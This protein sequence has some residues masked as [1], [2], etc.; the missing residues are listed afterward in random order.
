M[1]E[2]ERETQGGNTTNKS[3]LMIYRRSCAKNKKMGGIVSKQKKKGLLTQ[4]NHLLKDSKPVKF[5]KQESVSPSSSESS[6]GHLG[7]LHSTL[8]SPV[9]SDRFGEYL[10]NLDRADMLDEDDCGRAE[11]LEFVLAVQHLESCGKEEIP[12]LVTEIGETFFRPQGLD[13][14]NRE[15]WKKCK[16]FC[17][18]PKEN[19]L[20][21][22]VSFL[23]QAHNKVLD[24]L[25]PLHFH[26]LTELKPQTSCTQKLIGFIL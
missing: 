8:E 25:E 19:N 26:F 16:D 4:S 21:N 7:Q 24:R 12:R 22:G 18:A 3:L 17:L 1:G 6:Q 23:Q 10:K 15:L 5:K 11:Q 14:D 20:E 9:M 13:L 2:R